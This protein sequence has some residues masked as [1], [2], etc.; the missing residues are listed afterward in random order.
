MKKFLM[1]AIIGCAAAIL[2]APQSGATTRSQIRDK[3]TRFG[4]DME[5][6]AQKKG[7]HL[8][9]KMQGYKH[10]MHKMAESL[11]SRGEKEMTDTGID[12]SV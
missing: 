2:F 3:A 1:G 11:R 4:H 9:N 6:L 12:V 7:R 8:S 10:K 5:E